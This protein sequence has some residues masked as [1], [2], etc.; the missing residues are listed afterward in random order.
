MKNRKERR[1][2]LNKK[3]TV[4]CHAKFVYKE[5]SDLQ[6]DYINRED[7]RKIAKIF[8]EGYLSTKVK[9]GSGDII[10]PSGIDIWRLS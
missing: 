1:E 3:G 8:L 2:P 4:R 10:E 7:G 5:K 6:I 9:D